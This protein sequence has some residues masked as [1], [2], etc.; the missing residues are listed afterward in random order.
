MATIRNRVRKDGGITYT[1]LWRAGG[2]ADAKQ[3]SEIFPDSLENAEQKAELFKGL[4]NL[5]G[6]Q[7]PP[8]WVRGKGFV[9]PELEP[10]PT[11]FPSNQP[12]LEYARR[13]V[14]RLTGIDE[15]TRGDYHR[16]LRLH[17]EG[18]LVHT[19]PDGT[20]VPPTVGNVTK[21]DITEWVRAEEDGKVRHDD[22][23][24]WERQP[25]SPKSIKNRHGVLYSVFQAAVEAEPSLRSGN[26]CARTK[27]P[28]LDGGTEEEM[29]FL[30][31]SE[32]QRVRAELA[33]ICG[34]DGVDIAE[35]LVATGL[36]WGELTALQ[37]RDLNLSGSTPTLRVTRAWK[38]Q[39]DNS[40]KLGP[41]KTKRSRRTLALAPGTA[42]IVRRRIVAKGPEDFVFTT[43]WGNPW[44]HSNFYSRR[45][46]PAV[47]AAKAKGL[48]KSPRLHDLRHTHVSWLIAKN[49]PLPAIQA[50]LGHESIKT[51][52]D[53]YG[54]LVR[55]LDAEIAAAV[56]VAMTSTAGNGLHLVTA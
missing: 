41:P 14:D 48:P 28:R 3:E 38:R 22:P 55:E 32:W 26:P 17:V 30:E 50:R 8:G 2:K 44:R 56:E 49:I 37:V 47:K 54:H 11:A 4:V 25:A 51:T 18:V 46:L 20:V 15:R 45:W 16:E 1:V 12:L 36:R 31:Y 52:V 33:L 6:Q 53:R 10:E 19:A 7:W 9:Q 35:V 13:I 40:L 21:D 5:N 39:R 42:E 43:A 23:E 29:V 24:Q 27:L 34:G